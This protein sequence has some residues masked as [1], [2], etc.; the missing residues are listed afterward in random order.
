MNKQRRFSASWK[1]LRDN[2]PVIVAGLVYNPYHF[3]DHG[4]DLVAWK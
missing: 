3:R 4:I 2:Y 1:V